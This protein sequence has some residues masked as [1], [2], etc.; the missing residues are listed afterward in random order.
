MNTFCP[1]CEKETEV[2]LEN[3]NEEYQIRG[4]PILV[5]SQFYRCSVCG[6]EF[7]TSKQMDA[8]VREGYRKYRGQ[9]GIIFPEEI[10]E[11]R[12]KYN[13]SQKAFAKIL[14]LGELTINSFE[15]GSLPSKSVSNLIKLMEKPVNFTELFEKNRDRLTALQ[16][17]KIESSLAGQTGLTY[18][19][20]LDSIIE[21]KEKYTGYG[22]PDWEKFV[23]LFQLIIMFAKKELY[24]LAM[25]K[26][27]FY[28]DLTGFKC[29]VRSVSG[30]P[31]AA[32]DYGP[33]PE[34]WK[35]LLLQAEE[36]NLLQSKPDAMELGELFSLPG[37]FNPED[38]KKYFSD[39]EIHIIEEVTSRLKNK[40]A[41]E[42]CELSHEEA[43]WKETH[44]AKK[45]DYRLAGR[46][47]LF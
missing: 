37:D 8:A 27:A 38:A 7:A 33:V 12:K 40:T 41:K 2:F 46:L 1:N 42:L 9:E 23:A 43:A 39:E 3:R 19:A 31:Y 13:I 32:I 47:K 20:D 17:R 21:V 44:H 26:I 28:V 24:K 15:Q 4:K 35:S 16:V 5:K 36:S 29:L 30:W 45:I 10:I 18:R 22:K 11:I 6:E 34:D 14:D 25:L